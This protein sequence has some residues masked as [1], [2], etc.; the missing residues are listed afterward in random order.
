MP[1]AAFLVAMVGPLAARLLVALGLSLVTLTGMLEAVSALK[2]AVTSNIASLP[3]ATV[4][5]AGLYG[6]WDCLGMIFGTLTFCLTWAQTKGFWA[7][8]KT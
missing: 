3:A 1:I 5:L 8:A 4:Q 7:L 6:V 2:S